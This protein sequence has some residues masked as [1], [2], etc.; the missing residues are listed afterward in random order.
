VKLHFSFILLVVMMATAS[1]PIRAQ[2]Q[3]QS[4]ARTAQ[5]L[6][7]ADALERAE[8]Q[9][10]D[11]LAARAQMAVA[12]AGVRAAGQRPNHT[13]KLAAARDTPHESFFF[14]LPLEVGS[15]RHRRIE[16]AQQEGAVTGLDISALERQVRL[17]VRNAY[18]ALAFARAA[19]AERAGVLNLADRLHGIAKNRFE[20]GD[21][22]QLEVTQSELE[23]E[24]AGA[25]LQ[26][27][28]QEEKVALSDLNALLN[29]PA[30]LDW[31]LGEAL[32]S[33]PPVLTLDDLLTRSGNSN[34][35]IT[36]L[37]QEEKVQQSHTALLQ[38]ERIPNLGLQFGVDFNSPGPGGFREGARGALAVEL[39]LFSRYQGEI[40]ASIATQR[41]LE[42]QL[43]A[44]QRSISA[45]V[46]S[47]FFDLEARRAQVQLYREKLLPSSRQ[48][49]AMSEDSYKS[50]KANI[51][52]VLGAQRD[53]QQVERE[54]LDSALAM[55]AAFA[56][57][58]Q[59]V[60]TPLD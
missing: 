51:L 30:T 42:G 53:V 20:A 9:N 14:D 36:R 48:L 59:S 44:A 39:P 49:E 25:D 52:I 38:A 45:K 11:L 1:P 56:A 28:Q 41:A 4:S 32:A 5:K 29:E 58:E 33:Q 60:G 27:A 6:T 31:D 16:L 21:I 7:L 2:Q 54:Y 35:E 24:R 3:S 19:S 23:V 26:V 57:L 50:G 40:A 22:P 55:Q 17:N 34:A 18:Y 12:S 43:A 46:E 13:A 47:A 8:R 15:K 10:L 37:H